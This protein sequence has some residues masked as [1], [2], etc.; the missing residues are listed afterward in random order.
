MKHPWM[1]LYI[2][3]YL[4][5]TAHLSAAQSGAYLHLIMHYWQIGGLPTSD[6]ALARIAKMTLAEWKRSRDTIAEFFE[7]GW[8]HNRID[9]EIAHAD[10]ISSKRKAAAERRHGKSDANAQQEDT[11]AG[12]T[13]QSPS[14]VV[15]NKPN[16]LLSE[17]SSDASPKRARKSYPDDFEAFWKAYPTDANMSKTEAWDAW[18]KLS[19]EDRKAAAASIPGFKTYCSANPDYRPIHAGRYLSKRRFDGHLAKAQEVS[20]RAVIAP[21]SPQWEP[22]RTYYRD[23][24][25][26]FVVELMD[27][28]MRDGREFTVPSLWP[29]GHQPA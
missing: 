17:T 5:K 18:R 27:A 12:A 25:K 7:D 21:R 15:D 8:R 9:E 1:P 4:A 23:N 6:D 19:E 16:G 10:D 28:S 14:L 24:R 11:H 3:D 29:P 26:N 13:L 2:A 20:A 22:W